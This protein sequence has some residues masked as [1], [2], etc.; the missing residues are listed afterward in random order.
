LP[1]DRRRR[2]IAAKEVRPMY[3]TIARL[4]PSA[5]R[6]ADLAAYGD[7]IRD[8]A[9]PGYRESYLFRPDAN[10]YDRPT[11]FLVAVFDDEASYR[12]N[13]ESPGQHE[14]YLELRSMLDDDP[15]WMDGTFD[16]A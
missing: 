3:G 15:D 6:E 5:G 11:V 16:E 13:A 9:V 14:R 8:I 12:A 2:T 4:H 7:R 1:L 10:P